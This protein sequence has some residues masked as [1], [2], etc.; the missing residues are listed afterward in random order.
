LATSTWSGCFFSILL[1]R[2]AIYSKTSLSKISIFISS[3][4]MFTI[5]TP[6]PPTGFW[7]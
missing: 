3:F 7:W 4:L 2:S 6:Y 5:I 1:R